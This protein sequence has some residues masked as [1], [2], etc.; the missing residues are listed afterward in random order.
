[1]DLCRQSW[2]GF[3]EHYL[4]QYSFRLHLT[5]SDKLGPADLLQGGMLQYGTISLFLY[6]RR[7]K[8]PTKKNRV[9]LVLYMLGQV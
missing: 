3:N 9:V 7:S 5:H 4:E 8:T 1:M 6:H 2:R